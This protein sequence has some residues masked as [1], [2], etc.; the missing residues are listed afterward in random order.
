M[1]QL[2]KHAF[3]RAEGV[4]EAIAT[5]LQCLEENGGADALKQI[6]AKVPAY[7]SIRI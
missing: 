6:K 5:T 3:S 1:M 4:A 7:C 2:H